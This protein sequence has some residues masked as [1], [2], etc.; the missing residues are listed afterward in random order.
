MDD[1]HL[2]HDDA[3]ATGWMVE[4]TPRLP[5]DLW[6][7]L[8]QFALFALTGYVTVDPGERL[9]PT[10]IT[11]GTPA[12]E[13]ALLHD[14]RDSDFD[15]IILRFERALS[16]AASAGCLRL[17]GVQRRYREGRDSTTGIPDRAVIPADYFSGQTRGLDIPESRIIPASMWAEDSPLDDIRSGDS[18]ISEWQY[19]VVA[20]EDAI[21]FLRHS[22]PTLSLADADAD[23]ENATRAPANESRKTDEVSTFHRGYI[24]KDKAREL[25]KKRIDEWNESGNPH[26]P[27]RDEDESWGRDNHISRAM[28]RDIRRELLPEERRRR[29][30]PPHGKQHT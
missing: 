18:G 3:A 16:N 27:T 24:P 20:R 2:N 9:F 12:R 15:A 1:D 22:A 6:I 7:P 10:D 11:T 8:G 25:Y 5:D 17:M 19:V 13:G 26:S 30:R 29:G 28:M 21:S 23:A 4:I 14:T